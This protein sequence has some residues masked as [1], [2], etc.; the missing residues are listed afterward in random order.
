MHSGLTV[1]HHLVVSAAVQRDEQLARAWHMA[2]RSRMLQWRRGAR[3][4]W[5][6]GAVLG[7]ALALVACD[8]SASLDTSNQ[9][10]VPMVPFD[11]GIV[12]VDAAPTPIVI[13]A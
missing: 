1:C 3:R 8:Q 7:Y 4:A 12:V 2:W 5:W 11:S 13:D 6:G 9:P 10:V